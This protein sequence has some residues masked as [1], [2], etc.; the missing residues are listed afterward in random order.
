MKLPGCDGL[1][2]PFFE[3]GNRGKRSIG[4]DLTQEAGREHLYRLLENTDVFLTNMRADARQKL[5]IEPADLM[6]RNLRLIY[7]RGTGYGLHGQLA[8]DGGFDYPSAWCRAGAASNQ[9]FPSDEPP[10][11]PGS[12]GDLTGGVTLAVAAALFRRERTGK[13]AVVDNALYLVGS[14]LMSQSLLA[15]SIGAPLIPSERQKDSPFALANYRTRDGRWISIGVLMDKWWSDFVAHIERPQL[16]DDPRFK[17]A[18][19]RH[20]NSREL[21]GELNEVF[22]TRNYADWCQKLATMEC[23]WAPVQTPAEVLADPQA[24][25][26]G[27]V[28]LVQIDGG[29]E[30]LTGM[31]PAQFDERPIGALR[32]GPAFAQHTDEVLRELG[33]N[34]DELA[35]LREAGVVR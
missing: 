5:G 12:I 27:F 9:T 18:A 26:N 20:V 33:L 1:V 7:A 6:K 21:V 3:A 19:G 31:S 34:D 25:E 15:A 13:G 14:Y 16:L 29:Q 32:A 24:L 22:A 11:Q 4:L 17:D 28:S 10:K 23:V 2:N 35:S 30:Y 8:N